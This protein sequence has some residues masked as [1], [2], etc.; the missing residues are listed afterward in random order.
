V[1]RA[2]ARLLLFVLAAACMRLGLLIP[3]EWTDQGVIVYS[4]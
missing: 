2:R 4:I 1:K 3:I